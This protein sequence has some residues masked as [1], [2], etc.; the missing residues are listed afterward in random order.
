[1]YLAPLTLAL[2]IVGGESR[3]L[4]VEGP[5]RDLDFGSFGHAVGNAGDFDR[6]GYD[7]LV[8]GSPRS[9]MSG[10]PNSGSVFV[11]SGLTGALLHQYHLADLYA[12]F[13][14]DVAGCSD[15]DRDGTPDLLIGAPSA[16]VT[17]GSGGIGVAFLISGATGGEIGRF[18][19]VNGLDRLGDE[20]EAVGDWNLDGWLDFAIAGQYASS[21]GFYR[22]GAVLVISGRDRSLL[23]DFR[24]TRD[25]I[26]FGATLAGGGDLNADGIPDLLVC[27]PED[28]YQHPSQAGSITCISG[29]DGSI[30]F[31]QW[32]PVDLRGFGVSMAFIGDVNRDGQADYAVGMSDARVG[33]Q[34]YTGFVNCYSGRDQSL[35]WQRFG[36][37][38]Y[39]FFG[40]PLAT[41]GDVNGDGM[42][43]LLASSARHITV[44]NS[45]DGSVLVLS[46]DDGRLL[47]EYHERL[48]SEEFGVAAVGNLL[49]AHEPRTAVAVAAPAAGWFDAG[50]VSLF[51][52]DPWILASAN[53]VSAASGA[54]V[55]VDLDFPDEARQER[56]QILL[57]A[58]GTGPSSL[59]GLDLPLTQD[60]LFTRAL[61]GDRGMYSWSAGTS[62][63]L[64]YF[65]EAS[66]AVGFAAGALTGAI[67]RS[68]YL[69]AV[70]YSAPSA[71]RFATGAVRLTVL[72]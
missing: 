28:D 25:H 40:D 59:G 55:R 37:G 27:A 36:S 23:H 34:I 15:L 31:E 18:E 61:A 24:G 71:V 30:L 12:A 3:E 70:A 14:W 26:R 65:G 4:A 62:G 53:S 32:G 21:S 5:S 69:A 22:N 66:A 2:Q 10:L 57:S 9:N 46:G 33:G 58:T 60:G 47:L 29:A 6:D 19:G 35:L 42:P 39:D 51:R 72:P 52:Y 7:D 17:G 44:R 54:S 1:M 49:S 13:G 38:L 68:F 11:V 8:I 56:Y 20:V 16:D 41:A 50:R 63:R 48:F 45:P 64:G 43:D 67:G